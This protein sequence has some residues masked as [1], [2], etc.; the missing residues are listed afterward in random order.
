MTKN[1]TVGKPALLIV[2]FMLPL[3]LGNLFQQ[4][5][6][7]ADTFIVGRTLGREALAAVGCTGSL[8]FL[9]LGFLISTTQGAAIITSQRFGAGDMAGIRRSV[10]ASLILG[11]AVTAALTGLSLALTTPVL[12][13]LGTPPEIFEDSRA[14]ITIIFWGMPAA[15]IFNVLSNLMRCVGDSRTPLIFLVI[16]CMINIILDYALIFA[17][18]SVTGAAWATVIAQL[19]SG[20]LCV[21]VILRKLPL[22][23]PRREDWREGLRELG[24][25]ARQAIPMGFQMSIIALGAVMVTFA[26]NK[27]GTLAVAAF[28]T[29]QKIDQVAGMPLGSFGVAMTTYTAQNYGARK[30]RRIQTG[31]LQSFA[32]SAVFALVMFVLYFFAGD[33]FAALFL[34]GDIEAVR[35]SHTYLKITGSGYVILAGLFIF[36]GSLQGLGN[37]LVPTI[38]G[39]GELVMRVFAAVILG[40][41]AGFTGICFAGPLAFLGAF[42][43]LTIAI[44]LTMRR[45]L[46]P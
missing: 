7:V 38:A 22:L 36:R 37:S 35:M 4:F 32:M 2:A 14:Y 31:L 10:A 33:V 1:L 16:A 43:P 44:V 17:L 8:M 15:F 45:L 11:A 20:L 26:L 29:G 46:R 6:N 42:I 25:H 18:R 40:R 24:L 27:L 3:L 28:T 5:Y 41:Y 9:I 19:V 12:R 21:P 34:G 13:L 23:V 39:A 30:Y